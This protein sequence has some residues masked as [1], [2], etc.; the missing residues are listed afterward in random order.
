LGKY[1][2]LLHSYKIDIQEVKEQSQYSINL[3]SVDLSTRNQ[4]QDFDIW[5]RTSSLTSAEGKT[6]AELQ[7]LHV[8]WKPVYPRSVEDWRAWAGVNRLRQLA[9]VLL[10]DLS[11]R[12]APRDLLAADWNS[13]PELIQR[14]LRALSNE[15]P[16]VRIHEHKNSYAISRETLRRLKPILNEIYTTRWGEISRNDCFV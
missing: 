9:L 12:W 2:D 3:R 14:A 11:H 10:C 1:G 6:I 15:C 13:S 7:L 16:D 4:N 5:L 8:R